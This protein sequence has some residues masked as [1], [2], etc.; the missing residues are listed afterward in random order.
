[1]P[2]EF[3]RRFSEKQMV[4]NNLILRNVHIDEKP[5]KFLFACLYVDLSF[6][7]RQF[8]LALRQGIGMVEAAK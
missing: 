4:E 5:Q 7:E 1:M 8:N 2:M 6:M 3:I